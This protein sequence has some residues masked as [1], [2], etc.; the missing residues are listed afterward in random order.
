MSWG[1]LIQMRFFKKEFKLKKTLIF[2]YSFLKVI[3]H[4][5]HRKLAHDIALVRIKDPLEFNNH[6]IL[7]ICLP[8]TGRFPDYG[9]GFVAGWGQMKRGKNTCHTG[10]EGP[11]PFR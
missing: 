8:F 6:T 10:L 9:T 4:P 1:R 7:P 3:P 5:D 2:K 11:A